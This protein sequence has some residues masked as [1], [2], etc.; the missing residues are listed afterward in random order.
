MNT[1][2]SGG[3]GGEDKVQR[4]MFGLKKDK[5]IGGRRKLH[6]GELHNLHS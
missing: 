4:R 5:V 1:N 3:G 6:N 2:W